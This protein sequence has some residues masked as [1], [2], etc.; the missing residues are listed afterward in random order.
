LGKNG[1]QMR[2]FFLRQSQAG[3]CLWSEHYG[4]SQK[5]HVGQRWKHE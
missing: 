3:F 1:C 4:L 2:L 5:L